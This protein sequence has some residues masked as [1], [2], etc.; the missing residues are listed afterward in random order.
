[1][2]RTLPRC[3]TIGTTTNNFSVWVAH[4]PQTNREKLQI[5]ITINDPPYSPAVRDAASFSSSRM[6]FNYAAYNKRFTNSGALQ[7]HLNSSAHAP[8]FEFG[9]TRAPRLRK[10]FSYRSD[11]KRHIRFPTSE[12]SFK[13]EHQGYGESLS[14]RSHLERHIRSHTTGK[15]FKCE[16]QGC[17]SLSHTPD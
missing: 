11:L 16:H 8:V 17:A 12:K 3:A 1:V 7:Q 6:E 5:I 4:G 10:S 9:E 2:G 15:P 13:Y 14:R